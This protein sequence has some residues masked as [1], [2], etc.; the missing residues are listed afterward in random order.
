MIELSQ[1]QK[2]EM[3]RACELSAAPSTHLKPRLFPDGGRWC[4]LYG[5]N[6][7]DGLC[8]YGKT[9]EEAMA[10]FDHKF[11]TQTLILAN[12]S[13][14]VSPLAFGADPASAGSVTKVPKAWGLTA[15]V[16]SHFIA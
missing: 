7:Q 5:E 8:G 10:D 15:P 1:Y 14:Q 3:N 4:A 13:G 2:N 11:C 16:C 9:P 6:L 12:V